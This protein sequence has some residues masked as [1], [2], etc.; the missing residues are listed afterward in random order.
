MNWPDVEGSIPSRTFQRSAISG[1]S[2]I[3]VTPY[4]GIQKGFNGETPVRQNRKGRFDSCF[5]NLR[6]DGKC[7]MKLFFDTEFTGLHKNATLISVG[8]VSEY[9]RRFYAEFTDYDKNQCNDWIKE[10]VLSNLLLDGMGT[11]IGE[12]LDDPSTIM[13]RGDSQYVSQELNTWLSQFD[14]IWFVSDVCHYDFVFLIDL[15]T[16]G[17]TALDLPSN[18]SAVCHDINYDIAYHYGV[19]SSEAFDLSRERIMEQV[20]YEDDIVNGV[21]HNSLYDAEVIRAIWMEICSV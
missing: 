21:K 12:T 9:G 18:I 4:F 7:V 5:W 8:I 6:K 13:V 14:E 20:C 16:N 10:N 2:F 3:Y 11:G 19:S 15:I 17:G 1:K